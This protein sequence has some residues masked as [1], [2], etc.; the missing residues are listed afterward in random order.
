MVIVLCLIFRGWAPL[1]ANLFSFFGLLHVAFLKIGFPILL[2]LTCAL[3]HVLAIALTFLNLRAIYLHK[4]VLRSVK[5]SAL[6]F[7][8]AKLLTTLMLSYNTEL[9]L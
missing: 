8:N 1:A 6:G 3:P 2:R 7:F 9:F 5:C 4:N